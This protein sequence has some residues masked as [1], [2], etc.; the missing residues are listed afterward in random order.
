VTSTA[1]ERVEEVR[2]LIQLM[3]RV[4]ETVVASYDAVP[5]N[6]PDRRYWTLQQPAADCEQLVVWFNQAYMGTPGDEASIPQRCNGPRSA[7]LS[8]QVI[9][10]IPTVDS[11]GRPPSAEQIQRGSEQLAMDAWLLLDIANDLDQW[12]YPMAGPGLGVIATVE[13]GE[14]SGG[15]QGVTLNVA[16]GVPGYMV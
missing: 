7:A 3:E 10:C 15:F 9:R 16:L 8:I 2:A 12:D 13:A 5:M 4:L 11:R 1:P 6:L 14:P